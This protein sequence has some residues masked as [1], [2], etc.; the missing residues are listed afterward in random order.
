[1]LRPTPAHL[2]STVVF[3]GFLAGLAMLLGWRYIA[4][5]SLNLVSPPPPH[6]SDKP[7]YMVVF[8]YLE[9]RSGPPWWPAVLVYPL[10]GLGI[11]L[12]AAVLLVAA[13]RLGRM[14]RRAL[15]AG[16]WI[17]II[18]TGLL[19]GATTAQ[20]TRSSPPVIEVAAITESSHVVDP[21]EIESATGPLVAGDPPRFA[22]VPQTPALMVLG[23]AAG[24]L[25]GVAVQFALHN[26]RNRRDHDT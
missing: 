20:M 14:S 4:Q 1:M 5:R 17:A 3:S 18:G 26:C 6:G 15:L 25:G 21:A 19:V 16:L 13:R 2:T 11:G 22:S 23:I 9:Y 24:I 10:I 12:L 8:D 7:G